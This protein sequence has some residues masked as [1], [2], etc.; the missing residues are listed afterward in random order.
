MPWHQSVTAVCPWRAALMVRCN[1]NLEIWN[2]FPIS[3]NNQFPVIGKLFSDIMLSDHR[4]G[5]SSWSFSLILDSLILDS[6]VGLSA[7]IQSAG[8]S[9]P[10]TLWVR[11][12][13]SAEEDNLSHSDSNIACLNIEIK[14]K[15]L[16][17]PAPAACGHTLSFGDF[18]KYGHPVPRPDLTVRN[19]QL[20]AEGV[21]VKASLVCSNSTVFLRISWLY[22]SQHCELIRPMNLRDAHM[23]HGPG[24]SLTQIMAWCML[25]AK[26]LPE[27]ILIYNHLYP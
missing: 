1:G 8:D 4:D 21:T 15:H 3:E 27:P 20:S 7:D 26:P 9:V 10:E 18:T 22:F 6:S 11:I 5:L 2:L 23:H 24:S 17:T 16:A 14:K 12:L 25:G 13:H 19:C